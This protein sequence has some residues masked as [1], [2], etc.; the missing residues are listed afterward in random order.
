MAVAVWGR[1]DTK[2]T[3]LGF[4]QTKKIRRSKK[5]EIPANIVFDEQNK[6]LS[7]EESEGATSY[8]QNHPYL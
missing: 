3:G 2:L 8:L 4:V 6:T 1:Y 7:W 5:A